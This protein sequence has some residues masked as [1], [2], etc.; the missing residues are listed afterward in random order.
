[1]LPQKG[2]ETLAI[3][4]GWLTEHELRLRGAREKLYKAVEDIQ[5]ASEQGDD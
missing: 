1:M 5:N 3:C 4:R 2:F